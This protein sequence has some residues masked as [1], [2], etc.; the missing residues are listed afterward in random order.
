[1][2]FLT[3]P[4]G[5]NLIILLVISLA[6]FDMLFKRQDF[7][8]AC[9]DMFSKAYRRSG[10]GEPL[11]LQLYLTFV[12]EDGSEI[13]PLDSY[14]RP[15]DS[16]RLRASLS[17]SLDR[18]DVLKIKLMR[19]LSLALANHEKY[20]DLVPPLIGVKLYQEMPRVGKQAIDKNEKINLLISEVFK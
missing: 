7:P 1:M 14:I 13:L 19:L 6:M 16:L 3:R 12:V 17:N 18:P 4:V 2:R 15:L 9:F 11:S 8:F 10:L 20:P 5:V